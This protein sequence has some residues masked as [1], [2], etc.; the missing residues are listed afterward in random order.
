MLTCLALA[1]AFST[2]S[3]A[4]IPALSTEIAAEA[5]ALSIETQMTPA[6]LTRIGDFSSDAER[7][8]SLLQGAGVGQDMPCIFK[9]IAKDARDRAAEFRAADTDAERD[10]AFM[11]L[12]VLLDDAA[13]IAP[14]AATIAEDSTRQ[15]NIAPR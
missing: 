4:E 9:N 11:N 12:R 3:M 6:L 14:I 8:S 2:A 5:H 13:M 10:T 15:D 7:L 1:A